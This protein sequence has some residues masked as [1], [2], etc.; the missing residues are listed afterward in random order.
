MAAAAVS[1]EVWEDETIVEPE[2]ILFNDISESWY[3][4]MKYYLSSRNMP[5]YFDARK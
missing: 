1:E 4:D 5:E 2:S 3:M